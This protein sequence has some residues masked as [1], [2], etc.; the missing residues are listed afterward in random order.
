MKD[1]TLTWKDESGTYKIGY[2]QKL[3]GDTLKELERGN[4]LKLIIIILG[5]ITVAILVLIAFTGVMS[6]VMRQVVC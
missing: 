1:N 2:S 5:I 6:Q 4:I 3:Q